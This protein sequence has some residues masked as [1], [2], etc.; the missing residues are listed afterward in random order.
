MPSRL[1]QLWSQ[2]KFAIIMGLGQFADPR[3]IE[4]V[5]RTGGWDGVW[6]DQ[7]HV[8]HSIDQIEHCVRAAKLHG[9]DCFVRVAP[10]DYATIM[11]PLEAGAHG[12]MAA[13]IRSVEQAAQ[14]IEWARFYPQGLRGINGSGADNAFGAIPMADYLKK[15]ND[16]TYII[17][18]IEHIAAAEAV[19][20]IAALKHL[21]GLF[22]GPADLSQSMGLPAGLDHPDVVK[23]IERVAKAARANNVPWSILPKNAELAKK[24]MEWGCAMMSLGHDVVAIHRGLKALKEENEWLRR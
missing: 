1:Q 12:I 10:T 13:Q 19:E 20:K 16:E 11:R 24:C 15:A 5:G 22:I 14:V 2:K 7:E 23:V 9:I 3:F 6:V 8:G 21:G 4:M 18:Q 17:I